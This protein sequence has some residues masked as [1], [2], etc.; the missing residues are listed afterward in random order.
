MFAALNTDAG[1]QWLAAVIAAL[2]NAGWKPDVIIFDNVMSLLEGVQRDEE[3]WAAMMP[4]VRDITRQGIGQ[5]WIDHTGHNRDRQYGSSTK[6]WAFDA[7]GVMKPLP[8]EQQGSADVAFELS[9][10]APHGKARRR[11]PDNTVDFETCVIRLEH[12]VWTSEP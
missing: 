8:T 9:F 2:E 10:E 5:V 3:A 7:V 11:N 12:D 6:A 4:T 1:R